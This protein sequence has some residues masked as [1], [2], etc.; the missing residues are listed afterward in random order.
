[1]ETKQAKVDN[2]VRVIK[3]AITTLRENYAS[4]VGEYL[5]NVLQE[6]SENCTPPSDITRGEVED[7]VRYVLS[8][9]ENFNQLLVDLTKKYEKVKDQDDEE[10]L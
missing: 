5:G 6:L 7:L 8:F 4:E 9:Q 3:H 2:H 1:M 10:G